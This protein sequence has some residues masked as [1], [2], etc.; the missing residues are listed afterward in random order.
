MPTLKY[1]QIM[2]DCIVSRTEEVDGEC[3][4]EMVMDGDTV[5]VNKWY[6]Y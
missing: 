2:H 1:P 5:E 6:G 3:F 4:E